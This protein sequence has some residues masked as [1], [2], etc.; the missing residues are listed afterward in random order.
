MATIQAMEQ[1]CPGGCLPSLIMAFEN[2]RYMKGYTPEK[3]K[4]LT[5]LLGAGAD[6]GGTLYYFDKK[7]KSYTREEILALPGRKI[8][9][10]SC[11]SWMKDHTDYYVEGC[12]AHVLKLA[13]AVD[14]AT[15]TKNP[16]LK[17][18][19]TNPAF[20]AALL[21]SMGARYRMVK[22]GHP[23]DIE[24][25]LEDR[26][27]EGRP[28]SAEEQKKNFIP[29]QMPPLTKEQKKQQIRYILNSLG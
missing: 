19:I 11:T 20:M 22:A 14:Q 29:C 4:D 9:A 16:M 17:K 6:I 8:A 25:S 13:R 21:K 26:I 10:G 28:L 24:L 7:G 23:V 3:Y 5:V 18:V 2:Y 15:G 1:A 27:F 12:T